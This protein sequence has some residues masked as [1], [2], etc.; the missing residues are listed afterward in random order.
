M[1]ARL[2]WTSLL[3]HRV[4]CV[5]PPC[6]GGGCKT[7]APRDGAARALRGKQSLSA[8]AASAF[9]AAFSLGHAAP[10]SPAGSAEQAAPFG[11]T[12]IALPQHTD[13]V[14]MMQDVTPVID[15]E[16]L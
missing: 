15:I 4:S 8:I 10:G 13:G 3:L 9:A 14:V 1:L 6:S 2:L 7:T 16:E 11:R 12:A 5:D